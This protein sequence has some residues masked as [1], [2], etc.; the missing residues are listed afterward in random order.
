MEFK[1]TKEQ[2]AIRRMIREFAERKLAP[3]ATQID[4]DAKIPPD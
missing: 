4:R 1:L 3:I 2:E